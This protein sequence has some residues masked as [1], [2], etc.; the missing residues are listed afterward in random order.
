MR[1]SADD[2]RVP[3][4]LL[5]PPF[6][7]ASPPPERHDRYRVRPSCAD[8][9]DYAKIVD[10]ATP[11]DHGN[12]RRETRACNAGFPILL[13]A[14]RSTLTLLAPLVKGTPALKYTC[15]SCFSRRFSGKLPSRKVCLW[16]RG[17]A[18]LPLRPP[19]LIKE[20]RWFF[21]Y[22]PAVYDFNFD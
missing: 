7:T 11:N 14:A 5:S 6:R 21:V 17:E 15:V 8:E 22:S 20:P 4:P 10:C 12:V 13:R 16:V 1:A 2:G 18:L 9:P 3:H 19:R